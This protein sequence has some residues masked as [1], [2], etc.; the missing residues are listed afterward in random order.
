M[1]RGLVIRQVFIAL[2]VALAL[3]IVATGAVVVS[4]LVAPPESVS[5]SPTD[6]D[7]AMGEVTSLLTEV[8]S[9]QAYDVILDSGLFG[10]AG[11]WDPEA[12]PPPPPEPEVDPDVLDTELNL[13]LTGTIALEPTNPFSVAFIENL[14]Q[15]GSVAPYRI[16]EEVVQ[17]VKLLEVYP[18]EVILLNERNTPATK[19]RLRMDEEG[20]G[21][22]QR[23]P[24]PQPQVVA[25]ASGTENIELNRQEFIRELYV[26]Y[27]DLVTK[28]QPEMVRDASGKVIGVTANNISEVPLAKKLGLGDGDVLQTVNN[29]AIDSEQKILEMVQKYRNANTFRIGIMR[30]GKPKVITYRLN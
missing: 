5:A 4:G 21:E 9:R 29:E 18:R 15:R 16:E 11:A 22:Q 7:R 25:R 12:A 28:V 14:D 6:D 20:E 10:E 19:E 24:Q 26:N 3:L 17:K 27:A 1:V 2:D 30:E 8:D 13:S 23:R